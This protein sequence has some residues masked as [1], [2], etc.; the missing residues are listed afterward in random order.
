MTG[1]FNRSTVKV[2]S[3]NLQNCLTEFEQKFG[4]K[5]NVGNARFSKNNVVFKKEIEMSEEE[6]K[7]L[8]KFGW[9]TKVHK[10]RRLSCGTCIAHQRRVDELCDEMEVMIDRIAEEGGYK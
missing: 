4:V 2:L 3:D 1:T 5:V 8:W 10:F 7:A 9:K 6:K